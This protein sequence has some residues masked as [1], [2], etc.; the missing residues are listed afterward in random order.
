[1]L[2]QTT[3]LAPELTLAEARERLRNLPGDSYVVIASTRS[4]APDKP[5]VEWRSFKVRA[6]LERLDR[7]ALL[8]G[9]ARCLR[10]LLAEWPGPPEPTFQVDAVR[11]P[12]LD[13]LKGV[14]LDGQNPFGMLVGK[15]SRPS[16]GGSPRPVPGKGY[17][18]KVL[19]RE[20]GEPPERHKSL[21]VDFDLPESPVLDLP[22][23]DEP[24]SSAGAHPRR[25]RPSTRPS[26]RPS[27]RPPTPTP[28]RAFPDLAAPDSVAPGQAF[29]LTIGL[30][31]EAV[32]GVGGGAMEFATDEEEFDLEAH[33]L[34]EG[35]DA[36]EGLR[37]FLHV[38]RKEP[39][40]ARTTVRLVARE[41]EGPVLARVLL[42]DYLFAGSP[43]GRAW[44]GIAVLRAGSTAEE[45]P[46]PEPAGA[47]PVKMASPET[48]PDLT[49]Y[50]ENAA[51][52]GELLWRFATPHAGL[53]LPGDPVRTSLGSAADA[54][55]FAYE[56]VQSISESEGTHFLDNQLKGVARTIAGKMPAELW[57]LLGQVWKRVREAAE[58]GERPDGIPALLLMSAEAY[59][60]W[61]L[62]AAEEDYLDPALLDPKAPPFLG[63]QIRIGRWIPAGPGSPRGGSRPRIPPEAVAAVSHMAVVVGDYSVASGLRPLPEAESEGAH[64]QATYGASTLRATAAEI[65]S[66]FDDR[67]P[68]R[69][70]P[71]PIDALHFAC[72]GAMDLRRPEGNGI[73]L[74]EYDTRFTEVLVRGSELV[75]RRRPFVF[76]NACQVGQAEEMIGDYG[77][78]AGAFL[79]EDARAFIAPLWAVEDE[80]A[81]TLTVDFY[82][83][84]LTEGLPVAEALRRARARCDLTSEAPASTWLAYIFYGHP[85]LVLTRA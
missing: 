15:K 11:L 56:Q 54:R 51:G 84:T 78:M 43:C 41:I 42:V 4:K 18:V 29:D 44:R 71:E 3:V 77:G 26:A 75:R 85:R 34:A 35:F 14:V 23:V 36:P 59:I 52:G 22:S 50:I 30:A 74:D 62:A 24:T 48:A 83:Q 73:L 70:Q 66:L 12:H 9:K 55:T 40:A 81:H 19:G 31:P 82:R 33:V 21:G 63:A 38:R 46:T 10:D 13:V 72:H 80:L 39:H 58:A 79:A 65:D 32:P 61:E 25:P 53:S 27:T 47:T 7:A 76:L 1:V 16:F 60:P 20:G 57:A 68:S 17:G 69:K 49:V 28:L 5:A 2:F 8:A 45:G 37:R 67:W 64:L 6:L